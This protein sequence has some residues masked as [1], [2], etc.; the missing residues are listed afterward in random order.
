MA[1]TDLVQLGD[2]LSSGGVLLWWAWAEE[3]VRVGFCMCACGHEQRRM[4]GWP[5]PVA[6]AGHPPASSRSRIH[7]TGQSR[8]RRQRMRPRPTWR[9]QI[10]RSAKRQILS[11]SSTS[12]GRTCRRAQRDPPSASPTP[13]CRRL[14]PPG[15]IDFNFWSSLAIHCVARLNGS[16]IPSD[17]CNWSKIAV[18][19]IIPNSIDSQSFMD[20][21]VLTQNLG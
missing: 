15:K 3:D 19:E 17:A 8:G 21:M 20:A 13:G 18:V 6:K 4:R 5:G 7:E 12:P 2:G 9:R 10:V 11:V 16:P 14:Q 1:H